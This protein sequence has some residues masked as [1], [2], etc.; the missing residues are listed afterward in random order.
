MHADTSDER[1]VD[2]AFIYDSDILTAPPTE[3]F[4]HVIMRRHATREIL[5]VNFE[6]HQGQTWTVL[7]NHW[8][9]RS[10][11]E[12]ET[13]GYRAIAG[14]TLAFFHQRAG[15]VHGLDTPVLVM[16]DFNDEPFDYSLV[17]HALSTRQLTRV[18]NAKIP[19]LWNLMWEI[20]GNREGT[21]YFDR[22]PYVLDQ[23]L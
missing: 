11:G 18:R 15:E 5:Q 4:Q 7:G 9:A 20:L 17:R 2:V 14:E 1:G 6:T 23:I 22:L 10:G 13:S 8:P 19:R 3:V 16:G 21:F 12:Q